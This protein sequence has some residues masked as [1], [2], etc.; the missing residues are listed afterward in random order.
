[1]Y[2]KFYIA[3]F[4]MLLATGAGSCK[5]W[6]NLKPADGIVSDEF[7]KTKEQLAA[8][9]NGIYASLLGNP[10]GV[11]DRTIGEYL[12]MWGELRAD[13]VI[14]SSGASNNDIDIYNVN[15]LSTNTIVNWRAV[16][17]TINYCNTVITLGPGVM[18]QD[19]TLSEQQLNA[20]LAEART[21]R[22]LMY[23][24][25]VRSFGDVPLK[26]SATTSD[27]QLEQLPK[28]KQ[29]EVLDQIVSDLKE[30]EPVAVTTYGNKDFDKGRVTKYTV[31]ALMADVYLWMDKYNDCITACDK[32]INSGKFGLITSRSFFYQIFG[33]GNSNESIFEFQ[34]SKEALNPFYPLFLTNKRRYQAADAVMEDIYTVD[35]SNA[36]SIDYRADNASVQSSNNAIIKFIWDASADN[37]Y[38][39]WIVYRYADI[40]LMKAEAL[41][42]IGQGPEA[43]KIVYAIRQRGHAL[44]A[45]DHQPD[46]NSVDQVTDFILEERAREFAF[47]GKRWYDLLRNAKRNNYER[48]DI[49]LQMVTT[50]APPERQQSALN[51]YKDFNSH[52]FPIY[53]Y[54]LNT[55][56]NLEQNPFYQ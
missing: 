47:E 37:S 5:K 20:Y 45:T 10:A 28:S 31:Y 50:A 41:N 55:D 34:Y 21:I 22:A 15:L 53:Y 54:E 9:V 7:W 16:Y 49:L 3:L 14:P 56:K 52:Y 8:A 38:N 4:L 51:K 19:N 23:F 27:D 35:Y 2:R 32:V 18:K 25:L 48:L 12:F 43:V 39:H 17:R 1:M 30:A 13:M 44:A 29:A 6:L 40:L 42:Q 46:A 26:L 24:Y 33:A 36:D 11:S